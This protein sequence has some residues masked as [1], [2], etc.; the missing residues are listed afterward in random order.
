MLFFKSA[1]FFYVFF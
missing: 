1:K